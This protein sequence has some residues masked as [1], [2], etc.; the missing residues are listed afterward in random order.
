[1]FQTHSQGAATIGLAIGDDPMHPLQAQRQTLRNRQGCFDTIT[2]VAIPYADTE[3]WS[4]ITTHPETQEHLFEIV[5][6]VF[7]MPV[8]GPGGSHRLWFVRIGSIEGNRRAVLMQ[9]GSRDG[10]DL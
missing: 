8:S 5:T 6:P 7:A 3:G 2:V 10:V 4:S 1:M 9:P